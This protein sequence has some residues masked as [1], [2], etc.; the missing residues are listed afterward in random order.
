MINEELCITAIM[1]NTYSTNKLNNFKFD[2]PFPIYFNEPYSMALRD[3]T[4]PNLMYNINNGNNGLGL[5]FYK[6]HQNRNEVKPNQLTKYIGG[7]LHILELYMNLGVKDGYYN[8][9]ENFAQLLNSYAKIKYSDNNNLK[10]DQE[11]LT[12]LEVIGLVSLESAT[13]NDHSTFYKNGINF[14]NRGNMGYIEGLSLGALKESVKSRLTE[15]DDRLPTVFKPCKQLW[16]MFFEIPG[17]FSTSLI[18]GFNGETEAPHI[19]AN[20][21]PH[22]SIESVEAIQT[23]YKTSSQLFKQKLT[24]LRSWNV[25]DILYYSIEFY[26]AF[27]IYTDICQDRNTVGR[28]IKHTITPNVQKTLNDIHLNASKSSSGWIS[29]LISGIS[30]L[31]GCVPSDVE[32]LSSSIQEKVYTAINRRVDLF[33]SD[34]TKVITH[35]KNTHKNP[36]HYLQSI[37]KEF[38][39][40][41]P[42]LPHNSTTSLR[43]LIH[44]ELEY[45]FKRITQKG[46]NIVFEN[47]STSYKVKTIIAKLYTD[48]IEMSFQGSELEPFFGHQ[49]NIMLGNS[50]CVTL[51]QPAIRLRNTNFFLYCEQLKEQYVNNIMTPL[52][53]TVPVP[54]SSE[55][56]HPI[57]INME[58]PHFLNL[59]SN[60]LEHLKF[61]IKNRQGELLKF[62]DTSQTIILLLL[63]RP[64]KRGII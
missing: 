10:A 42:N 14:L 57:H 38:I 53:A 13:I 39:Y 28:G 56:G 49:G 8:S 34:L 12:K 26:T 18:Y 35:I 45:F 47:K 31:T 4:Y 11:L 51:F 27:L 5:A 7:N 33:F 22:L 40:I 1:D 58:N 59:N 44:H 15:N 36:I 19:E 64:T 52:F 6:Q 3:I 50:E 61:S 25:R 60:H 54:P 23:L 32:S 62:A 17:I 20:Y 24:T 21:F 30:D 46:S 63:L 29:G 16:D 9:V 48:Y 55:Y 37:Q 43:H 2:L 41:D